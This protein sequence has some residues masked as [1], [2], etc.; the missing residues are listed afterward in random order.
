[1][2]L[3]KMQGHHKDEPAE[4]RAQRQGWPGAS[5]QILAI[6]TI[7]IYFKS[8]ASN[9]VLTIKMCPGDNWNS[10]SS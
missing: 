8:K 5:V 7:I 9:T 4:D 6:D 3:W 1:M 2:A 10:A